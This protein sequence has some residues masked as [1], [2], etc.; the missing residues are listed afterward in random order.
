MGILLRRLG[1]FSQEDDP[2]WEEDYRAEMRERERADFRWR[3]YRA[4]QLYWRLKGIE[5]FTAYRLAAEVWGFG[6]EHPWVP[7]H[8]LKANLWMDVQG[9]QYYAGGGDGSR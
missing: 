4:E 6:S 5:D 3:Q 8:W 1:V 2:R 9:V 7:D